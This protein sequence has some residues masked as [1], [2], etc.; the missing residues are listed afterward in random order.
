MIGCL[1]VEWMLWKKKKNPDLKNL[2]SPN[3][4]ATY[5]DLE[6]SKKNSCEKIIMNTILKKK[7]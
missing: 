2:D 1:I 5:P 6:N 3:P 4:D 7:K